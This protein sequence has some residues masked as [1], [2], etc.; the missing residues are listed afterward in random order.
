MNTGRTFVLAGVLPTL[1]LLAACGGGNGNC[2]P[3]DPS[4][5]GG[6]GGGAVASIKVTPRG[7][8]NL[9]ESK[10]L[11]ATATALDAA[12][13]PVS[14]QT[15]QWTTSNAKVVALS[16]ASGATVTLT[17]S[18]TLQTTATVT[19]TSG[20]FSDQIA[21]TVTPIEVTASDFHFTPATVNIHAGNTVHWTGLAGEHDVVFDNDAFGQ[22]HDIGIPAQSGSVTFKT[23]GNYSYVC[24]PHQSNGMTG[25]VIVQ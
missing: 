20:S 4:C 7:S 25:D 22:T 3:T 19:V 8:L 21:I 6:G 15:F 9:A 17:A 10:T 11:S 13:N 2:A 1:A 16:S 5:G 18:D 14:G 23:A 12:G 24:V